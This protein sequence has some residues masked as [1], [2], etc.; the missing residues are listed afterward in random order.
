[1]IDLL[2]LLLIAVVLL[3]FV[4]RRRLSRLGRGVGGG[5]REF[6]RARAGLPPFDPGL[7]EDE[8]PVPPERSGACFDARLELSLSGS[9]RSRILRDRDRGAEREQQRQLRERRRRAPS[10]ATYAVADGARES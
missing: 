3:A 6:R 9:P 8:H 7:K 5:V 4:G 10:G 1:M 2:V